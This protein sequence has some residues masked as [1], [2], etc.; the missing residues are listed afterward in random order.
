MSDLSNLDPELQRFLRFV[1]SSTDIVLSVESFADGSDVIL[2][3]I[4]E[5]FQL[6]RLDPFGVE[7]SR[8]Y[9]DRP[10]TS[11][12]LGADGAIYVVGDYYGQTGGV[13]SLDSYLARYDLRSGLIW[14]SDFGSYKTDQVAALSVAEDGFI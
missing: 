12:A 7:L 3:K 8:I 14:R 6:I 10:A 2:A 9:L 1:S 4:S 5:S 13:R 11:I